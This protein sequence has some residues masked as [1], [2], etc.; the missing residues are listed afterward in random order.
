MSKKNDGKRKKGE[1]EG[2]STIHL[3]E[4]VSGKDNVEMNGLAQS[5]FKEALN[6]DTEGVGLAPTRSGSIYNKKPDVTNLST[7]FQTKVLNHYVN[8]HIGQS[9]AQKIFDIAKSAFGVRLKN[10]KDAGNVVYISDGTTS[11]IMKEHLDLAIADIDMMGVKAFNNINDVRTYL[12]PYYNMTIK[13]KKGEGAAA[14]LS[15]TLSDSFCEKFMYEYL[16]DQ[17][18]ISRANKARVAVTSRIAPSLQAAAV[19]YAC[20][21]GPKG[22]LFPKDPNGIPA[23]LAGNIDAYCKFRSGFWY[24]NERAN[25]FGC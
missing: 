17:S 6:F 7:E 14:S 3:S 21:C 23:E 4:T 8:K 13:A 12:Q 19:T 15:D 5:L 9:A 10:Y 24:E 22:E 16:P 25:G 11:K 2:V 20:M 1:K 18:A